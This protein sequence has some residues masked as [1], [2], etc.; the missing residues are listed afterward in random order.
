MHL[1]AVLSARGIEVK[2]AAIIVFHMVDLV[3]FVV[4]K[5]CLFLQAV[6]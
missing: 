1:F 6:N 4:F 5:T 2:C 3:T